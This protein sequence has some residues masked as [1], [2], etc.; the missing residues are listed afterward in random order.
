M[1]LRKPAVDALAK[2]YERLLEIGEEGA[3]I[4]LTGNAI[5]FVKN[6]LAREGIAHQIIQ[7]KSWTYL[8][9]PDEPELAPIFFIF[10]HQD[11]SDDPKYWNHHNPYEQINKI[12][13]EGNDQLV[14]LFNVLNVPLV[15][16][17]WLE[18]YGEA[19]LFRTTL[20]EL[21]VI[22]KPTPLLR[23]RILEV[24]AG[25]YEDFQ[26]FRLL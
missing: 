23:P 25:W 2:T 3:F 10:Y 7:N 1:S 5:D 19:H 9:F 18:G 26:L 24:W 14:S 15:N 12:I 17:T 21:C 4:A 11:F 13:I 16:K 22:P 6:A 8:N 20:N